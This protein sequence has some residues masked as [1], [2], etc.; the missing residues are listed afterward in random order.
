MRVLI[1]RDVSRD[2]IDLFAAP[3]DPEWLTHPKSEIEWFFQKFHRANPEVYRRLERGAL[4]WADTNPKRIGVRRLIENLRYSAIKMS[5]AFW[6]EFKFN[7]RC[8]PLYARLLIHRHPRLHGVI[9]LRRRR[10]QGASVE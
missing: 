8:A 5:D 6:N 9:E 4:A 2:Q 1:A 10:E 3:D 7:D